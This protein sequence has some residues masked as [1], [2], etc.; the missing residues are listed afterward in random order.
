MD[1]R[2]S[3]FAYIFLMIAAQIDIPTLLEIVDDALAW[4]W[5][6]A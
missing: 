6:P 1:T 4:S 5:I 3:R 2:H